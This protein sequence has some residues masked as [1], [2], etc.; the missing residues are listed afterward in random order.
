MTETP[1][2]DSNL[3]EPNTAEANPPSEPIVPAMPI[4]GLDSSPP[5]LAPSLLSKA[6]G[7]N[8]TITVDMMSGCS[9]VQQQC[10]DEHYEANTVQ[11]TP[12]PNTPES[13]VSTPH[14]QHPVSRPPPQRPIDLFE[15]NE[16]DKGVEDSAAAKIWD[17]FFIDRVAAYKRLKE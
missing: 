6:N 2:S 11:F 13:I 14:M 1:T 15:P 8:M 12:I 3:V 10:L 5:S 16:V 17:E 9:N 7:Q 4:L